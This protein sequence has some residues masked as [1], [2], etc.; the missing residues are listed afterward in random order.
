MAVRGF[1][2]DE[3]Y[4]L[5]TS[6]SGENG[7]LRILDLYGVGETDCQCE[8][9]YGT[10]GESKIVVADNAFEDSIRLEKI[11]L[12]AKLEA[13]GSPTF[14]GCA[15]LE[16]VDF[17]ESLTSI[18][19]EAFLDCPKL[20]E[21]YI[22]KNLSLGEVYNYAFSASANSFVCDWN[23]W[24]VN[25]KGEP[26]YKDDGFGFFSYNGV[27][28]FGFEWDE[29]VELEKYPSNSKRSIYKVPHGTN[30]IKNG[31]FSNC[32]FLQKLVFPETCGEFTEGSIC[33]CPELETLVFMSPGFDGE[34]V[35]HMDLFWGDVIR[36]CP[37]LQDVY[38]YAEDPE[39]VSFGIFEN[40]ENLASITLHVPCFCAQ[41]YREHKEEYTNVGNFSDKKFIKSWLKFKCIEEFDP[42]DL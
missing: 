4:E 1:L 13:I 9:S 29:S 32:K 16:G 41:R 33:G 21:V 36:N 25:E 39:M 18:G 7:S 15:N 14:G 6:M 37:K 23:Q 31:A 22:S 3:D 27:L 28:F 20:G 34:K 11:I 5:L 12:P 35:H 40:L 30:I 2:C 38:L 42:I 19:S 26:V 10:N 17:P 8:N 24:P